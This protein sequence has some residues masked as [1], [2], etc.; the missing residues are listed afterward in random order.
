M[1]GVSD[2]SLFRCRKKKS[3][4]S[5]NCF[6]KGL[7]TFIL[8]VQESIIIIRFFMSYFRNPIQSMI[9]N[10]MDLFIDKLVFFEIIQIEDSQP[11]PYLI[12]LPKGLCNILVSMI[13][14]NFS[15]MTQ[16]LKLHNVVG[17]FFDNTLSAPC[18]CDQFC[19]FLDFWVGVSRSD[20]KTDNLHNFQI[21]QVI[22]YVHY[23]V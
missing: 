1:L 20:R 18:L 16:A 10:C 11:W 15:H 21:I 7:H 14:S 9:L 6:T 23:F 22:P 4:S 17:H 5:L 19:D 3:Y 8:C 12:D 2:I 13:P